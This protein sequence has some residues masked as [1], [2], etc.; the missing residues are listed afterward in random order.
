ML[1]K[2]KTKQ[3]FNESGVSLVGWRVML[4]VLVMKKSR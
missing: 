1:A 3:M 2:G 4:V